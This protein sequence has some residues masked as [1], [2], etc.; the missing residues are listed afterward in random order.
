[1]ARPESTKLGSPVPQ[2]RRAAA[3][4]GIWVIPWLVLPIVRFREVSA[5]PAMRSANACWSKLLRWLALVRCPW[6]ASLPQGAVVHG[7]ATGA[8]TLDKPREV[9]AREHGDLPDA[10]LGPGALSPGHWLG[11]LGRG[12]GARHVVRVH[13]LRHGCGTGVGPRLELCRAGLGVFQ[14]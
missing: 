12:R 10:Q 6:V 11:R 5:E 4:V 8:P 9:L 3:C 7:P 13:V 2:N 14:A 1:M